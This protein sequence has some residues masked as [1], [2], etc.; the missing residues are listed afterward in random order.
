MIDTWSSLLLAYGAS[1]VCRRIVSAASSNEVGSISCFSFLRNSQSEVFKSAAFA[2]TG[3]SPRVCLLL[4][5]D[6]H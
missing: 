2:E 5:F 1:H 3:T 4:F 6:D